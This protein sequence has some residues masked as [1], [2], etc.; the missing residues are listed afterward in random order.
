MLGRELL[1][2]DF[3]AQLVLAGLKRGDE[4]V[5][6]L[7][8][9]FRVGEEQTKVQ[10]TGAGLV[11]D[12][13]LRGGLEHCS[14]WA[15]SRLDL[16]VSDVDAIAVTVLHHAHVC[17]L[18]PIHLIGPTM[19]LNHVNKSIDS[20]GVTSS[21]ADNALHLVRQLGAQFAAVLDDSHLENVVRNEVD[22][23]N[24][25]VD[26]WGTERVFLELDDAF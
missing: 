26:A 13:K 20:D 17:E 4:L 9:V 1:R 12:H 3:D 19:Q 14:P 10:Q 24:R 16:H 25:N 11:L 2:V 18:A 5:R 21:S 23:L 8:H 6:R 7:G 15:C 22:L